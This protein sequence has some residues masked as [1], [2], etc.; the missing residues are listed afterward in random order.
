MISFTMIPWMTTSLL[1]KTLLSLPTLSA[2]IRFP[3]LQRCVVPRLHLSYPQGQC[4]EGKG[5]QHGPVFGGG[6][7]DGGNSHPVAA[8]GVDMVQSAASLDDGAK[9]VIKVAVGVVCMGVEEFRK[10]TNYF[11]IVFIHTESARAGALLVSLHLP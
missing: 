10:Q 3:R 8:E 5:G 1:W 2:K 4:L 7:G 6:V 9:A 11:S